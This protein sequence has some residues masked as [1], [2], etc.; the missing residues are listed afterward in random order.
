MNTCIKC[1]ESIDNK[2][3]IHITICY[4]LCMDAMEKDC[5]CAF[6]DESPSFVS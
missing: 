6:R 1:E 5:I 3:D 2:T 4:L